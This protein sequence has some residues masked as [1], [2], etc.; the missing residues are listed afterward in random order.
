MITLG[1]IIIWDPGSI[2][3]MQFWNVNE[4][5]TRKSP[6]TYTIPVI[7]LPINAEFGKDVPWPI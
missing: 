2:L 7:E 1:Q 6:A 5:F 4:L 3:T